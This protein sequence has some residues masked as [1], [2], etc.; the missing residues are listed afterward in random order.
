MYVSSR[1]PRIERSEIH[2][3][4]GRGANT[5]LIKGENG[6]FQFDLNGGYKEYSLNRM[7]G[8]SH[9]NP[10]HLIEDGIV[11][12]DNSQQYVVKVGNSLYGVFLP[13]RVATCSE[14]IVRR[15]GESARLSDQ[16]VVIGPNYQRLRRQGVQSRHQR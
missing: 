4:N 2:R 9:L 12:D 10:R 7:S 13:H 6:L 14:K 1:L 15:L 16:M 8:K 11:F 3:I 5:F